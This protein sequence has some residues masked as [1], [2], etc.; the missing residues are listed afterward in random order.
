MNLWTT[1]QTTASTQLHC[2]AIKVKVLVQWK[3]LIAARWH[4]RLTQDRCEAPPDPD[5][6]AVLALRQAFD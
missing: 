1:R 6:V 4:F 3:V 5:G 2:N